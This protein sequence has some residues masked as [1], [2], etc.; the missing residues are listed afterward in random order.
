MKDNVIFCKSFVFKT[1]Q[2]KRYKHNDISAGAPRNFFALMVKGTGKLCTENETVNIREGD[3]FF[4]PSGCR[5][6]SYWSGEN[7]IEFISLGFLFMPNFEKRY[8]PPQV[9]EKSDDAVALMHEI[10]VSPLDC[11]NVGR[12]Y[13]LSGMLIPRMVHG[14]MGKQSELVEK[15]RRLIALDPYRTVSEL[16]KECTV[17]ESTLYSTFKKHSRESIGEIRKGLLL[18]K[19]KELLVSTDTPIEEIS[20]RLRFSSSSY[21]RK[22]FKEHFGASPREMRQKEGL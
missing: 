13:T 21:F 9:I 10:A 4:I 22:C 18:E 17:S 5:Y 15:V 19:A 12:L 3:I 16:A 2:L 14:S 7:D 20:A 8:Y 1:F 11:V 6:H